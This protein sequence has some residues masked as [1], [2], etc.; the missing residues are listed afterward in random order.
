M[1]RIQASMRTLQHKKWLPVVP[2]VLIKSEP[3]HDD[4]SAMA[5]SPSDQS[6]C[7]VHIELVVTCQIRI[8]IHPRYLAF[9]FMTWRQYN[10]IEQKYFLNNIVRVRSR[11]SNLD[12][13]KLCKTLTRARIGKTQPYRLTYLSNP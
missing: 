8:G 13:L 11:T 3:R 1:F 5:K 7:T 4:D 12:R 6:Q 2:H 9:N 10:A